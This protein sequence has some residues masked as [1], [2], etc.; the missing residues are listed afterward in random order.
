MATACDNRVPYYDKDGLVSISGL[1][2]ESQ[3][4]NISGQELEISGSGFGNDPKGVTV[5]FGHQNAEILQASDSLLTVRVPHG[6]VTGGAVDVRVGNALGQD[7]IEDAYR[8]DIPGN[9][10]EPVWGTVNSENQIAYISV[11]NDCL[12]YTSPSP[13]DS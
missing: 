9:G 1:S 13:R 4:G 7:S 8:Y 3:E 10:M 11:A 6:P 2:V 12:L 5:M